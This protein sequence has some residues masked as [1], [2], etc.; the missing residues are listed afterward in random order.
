[1]PVESPVA[2]PRPGGLS[3]LLA[4][5]P[6][7][8]VVAFSMVAAFV[9]YFC[10]YSF[11]KPFDATEFN[12]RAADGALV[13]NDQGKVM[14][15]KFA[16]TPVDLK[17]MCVIAQV[18]GYCLSKY[19]GTRVC[20]EVKARYRGYLLVGLILW[21]AAALALFGVLPPNLKPLAMFLNGLPLGMVWGLCVRYLEGRRATELMIAGLSCSY[22]VAGA[23]TR[24]VGRDVV[25]KQWGVA[26]EFMPVATG[27]LFLLP[28]ALGVWLLGRIPAPT[29]ADTAARGERTEMSRTA[30][31]AFL[32]HYGLGF[33]LLLAAYFFLTMFRDFRDHYGK[34]VFRALGYGDGKA[35][36]TQTEWPAGFSVLAALAC[37]FLIRR[38]QAALV[39]VYAVIA[40]GFALVGVA[41]ALYLAG[42]ID[43]FWMMLLFAVGLY[44]AYVPYGA[45]LFERMM[46]ASR[47]A[48]T[49]AFAIQLADGVGYTGSVI[50]QLLRDFAFGEFDRLWFVVRLGLVV[51]VA[52]VLLM[53][54][55][56]ILCVRRAKP[57]EGV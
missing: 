16:G 26:E 27:L 56:G 32:R 37:L 48:G 33:G 4:R 3:G 55:S 23:M 40:A 18:I 41:A 6:L 12:S 19:L 8:V 43:G 10:M 49:A 11:R 24:D 31:W 53:T 47:F 30:R 5:A 36:F 14:P 38:H 17:T 29:A 35:I 13:L 15:V 2:P 34:E 22:V 52:G 7:A 28:F 57:V 39:A 44:L 42:V 50:I 46:A 1:M 9:T 20:S 21:A 54:A 51:S 25:M 45:M